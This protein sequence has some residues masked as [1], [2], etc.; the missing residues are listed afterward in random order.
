MDLRNLTRLFLLALIWGASFLCMRV[1]V[2][3]LGP[4]ALMEARVGLAAGLLGILALRA[5]K[6]FWPRGH[7]LDFWVLGL[8]N[9]ALPFVLYAWAAQ[10][11]NASTLSILNATSPIWGAFW[12]VLWLR[13]LPGLRAGVGLLVGLCGV[14][15]VVGFDPTA[16]TPGGLLAYAAG[17]LAPCCYG[18]ATTWMKTRRNGPD[19]AQAA[20]GSMFAASLV[21]LPCLPFAPPAAL[22]SAWGVLAVLVLGLVCTGVAYQMYFRL[23]EET[24]PT[25]ALTVTFL[26]PVFGVL[27]GHLL[28]GEALSARSLVGA[29]VVIAGTALS[30]GFSLRK[31][32]AQTP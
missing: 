21:L 17:V 27:W 5:G 29:A 31:L 23:V 20:Q 18:L 3:A 2:P 10:T 1:A 6:P 25:R 32:L 28:L 16:Q 19:P 13:Q 26:V 12:G 22:P 30:T 24:G 15:L 7:W 14:G 4:I 9:T 11:L 8:L